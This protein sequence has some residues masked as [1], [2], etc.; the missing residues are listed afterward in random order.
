MCRRLVDGI[1]CGLF[2][3]HQHL[4]VTG[5]VN[6]LAEHFRRNVESALDKPSDETSHAKVLN[7]SRRLR[8][9]PLILV[10]SWFWGSK[11]STSGDITKSLDKDLKQ[12]LDEQQPQRYI[13]TDEQFPKTAPK[14]ETSPG[15][16][17]SPNL[18]D[19]GVPKESLFQDG[20]YKDIWKTYVPQQEIIESTTTPLDRISSAK[21]DRKASLHQAAM[22]NCAFEE[23]MKRNCF[24]AGDTIDQL[25]ARLT[26]C[27]RETRAFNRCFQLQAK[28][29]QALGYQGS[30][31][32]TVE[33]DERVQMHADRLYHRMMDY[34]TAVDEAKATGKPVPPLTSVFDASKPSP[35]IE[36]MRLP[37]NLEG[38]IPTE[39]RKLPPHER[40]LSA[41]A[42][43]QEARIT[44]TYAADFFNY[45]TTLN[46]D[47]KDRQRR[48]IDT[49]GEAVGKFLVPD[50]PSEHEIKTF[51]NEELERDFWK[52]EFSKMPSLK[53]DAPP[54]VRDKD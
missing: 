33:E 39:L 28:F 20:R 48:L 13:T 27:A 8:S 35:T 41:R 11:S 30:A 7:R 10:M 51:K 3:G 4:T 18:T 2:T 21:K 43:L 24:Q 40:E 29:M 54:R 12:F 53:L 31:Y 34:E 9:R 14:V 26:M 42:A 25:R 5:R 15:P 38:T 23:E 1:P 45:T 19:S 22:E 32:S 36:E 52:D 17:S 46:E 44:Q 16:S 47:R 37:A 49:F 6:P 50:P